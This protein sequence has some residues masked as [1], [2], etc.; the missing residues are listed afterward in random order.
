MEGARR[1]RNSHGVRSTSVGD[2]CPQFSSPLPAR[3]NYKTGAGDTATANVDGEL[4]RPGAPS[5]YRPVSRQNLLHA[6][7]FHTH[8]HH[9]KQLNPSL[10]IP[11]LPL[12][13]IEFKGPVKILKKKKGKTTQSNVIHLI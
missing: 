11:Q 13:F 2:F 1:N 10:E 6:F 8:V 4:N 9:C 5:K 3:N 12:H 7:H